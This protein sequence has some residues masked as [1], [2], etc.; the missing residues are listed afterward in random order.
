MVKRERF[1]FYFFSLN[2]IILLLYIVLFPGIIR[3]YAEKQL[4]EMNVKFTSLDLNI[5]GALQLTD[6]VY[7]S[8]EISI[9][10]D[11]IKTK[12]DIFSLLFKRYRLKDLILSKPRITIKKSSESSA[13]KP[14]LKISHLKVIEGEFT[15]PYGNVEQIFLTGSIDLPNDEI[16]LNSLSCRSSI[17]NAF[18]D[19]SIASASGKF[20]LSPTGVLLVEEIIARTPLSTVTGEGMINKNGLLLDCRTDKFY[21]EEL[22]RHFLMMDDDG[23]R[24]VAAG[25][26]KLDIDAE[27]KSIIVT[28][29]GKSDMVDIY[30]IPL[31]NLTVSFVFDALNQRIDFTSPSVSI[32]GGDG[33]ATA[34]YTPDALYVSGNVKNFPLREILEYPEDNSC[35]SGD[36]VINATFSSITD[37]S[38]N[39]EGKKIC[40][41]LFGYELEENTSIV[42]IQ[43]ESNKVY[44]TKLEAF[45]ADSGHAL[46]QGYGDTETE[47]YHLDI[48][49]IKFKVPDLPESFI[50][51]KATVIS[52]PENTILDI[53]PEKLI[54]FNNEVFAPMKLSGRVISDLDK[55]GDFTGE[56]SVDRIVLKLGDQRFDLGAAHSKT[57]MKDRKV[58]VD[59]RLISNMS[60]K[61]LEFSHMKNGNWSLKG[62]L[63]GFK[64]RAN[65]ISDTFAVRTDLSATPDTIWGEV[66]LLPVMMGNAP[67]TRGIKAD[68]KRSKTGVNVDLVGDI[69]MGSIFLDKD[70]KILSEVLLNTFPAAVFH[71]IIVDDFSGL[72]GT[73]DGSIKFFGSLDAPGFEFYLKGNGFARDDRYFGLLETSGKYEQGRLNFYELTA[74]RKEYSLGIRGFLPVNISLFPFSVNP[75]EGDIN[76]EADLKDVRMGILDFLFRDIPYI[77]GLKPLEIEWLQLRTGKISGKALVKG[78]SDDPLIDSKLIASDI[79]GSVALKDF[80]SD[81]SSMN[82][83][84]SWSRSSGIDTLLVNSLSFRLGEEKQSGIFGLNAAVSVNRSV[85]LGRLKLDL[86]EGEYPVSGD[87]YSLIISSLSSGL[88]M[89]EDDRRLDGSIVLK[90]IRIKRE[91]VSVFDIIVDA[92]QQKESRTPLIGGNLTL[93]EDDETQLDFLVKTENAA[94]LIGS[95]QNI[96]FSTEGVSLRGTPEK[97]RIAGSI[98]ILEGSI[99]GFG[100]EFAFLPSSINFRNREIFDPFIAFQLESTIKGNRINIKAAGSLSSPQITLASIPHL[101]FSE[102]FSLMLFKRKDL[103]GEGADLVS[104]GLDLLLSELTTGLFKLTRNTAFGYLTSMIFDTIKIERIATEGLETSQLDSRWKFSMGKYLFPDLYIGYSR[105]EDSL[106]DQQMEFKFY[107]NPRLVLSL[108]LNISPYD[109]RS[110]GDSIYIMFIRN[111]ELTSLFK[112][113]K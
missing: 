41:E 3:N 98:D 74:Y 47:K 69:I 30:A 56:I 18:R 92:L 36:V 79:S 2:L 82:G 65:S 89:T 91:I 21:L 1:F 70:L 64:H 93:F 16:I 112:V 48:K 7:E 106:Y 103:T 40:G 45:L 86:K 4:G 26:F 75:G 10:S 71:D 43:V 15:F 29:T 35:I 95:S 54:L 88:T 17:D 8:S 46:L 66:D 38:V 108:N 105:Y 13:D 51:G 58:S 102:I 113:G 49:D 62:D 20:K 73:V 107:I 94:F 83:D 32:W 31:K 14:D 33:V 84:I 90:D 9:S 96:S 76:M 97:V 12:V 87:D 59:A 22:H 34:C 104:V 55:R 24:G 19:L 77:L 27:K 6:L 100:N 50:F 39:I 44:F 25:Y 37:Y 53:V 101:S 99:R 85:P 80:K 81:F 67:L 5:N 57:E 109:T 42:N 28:G 63:E 60:D 52:S 61:A 68:F 110:F 111:F 72:S 11:Y 78:S 23:L